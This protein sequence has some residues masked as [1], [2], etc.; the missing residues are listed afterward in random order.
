MIYLNE[1][2]AVIALILMAL[3]AKGF[4]S[5]MTLRGHSPVNYLMQGILIGS[6]GI[7]GRIALYDFIRPVMRFYEVLPGPGM[8]IDTQLYNAGFNTLFALAAWRILVALHAALP[9]AARADY[10]WLSA[11]F[12][13][14][15]INLFRR[16]D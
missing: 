6:M 13:P 2:T 3:V 15:R 16:N 10:T 11:P 9:E 8:G 7:S 14:R 12:Y 4:G 5:H 1:M